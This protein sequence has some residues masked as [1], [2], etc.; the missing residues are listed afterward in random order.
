[1]SVSMCMTVYDW[2]QSSVYILIAVFVVV[3]VVFRSIYI[4]EY[5]ISHTKLMNISTLIIKEN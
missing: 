4:C 2:I 1:M 5:S 3:V